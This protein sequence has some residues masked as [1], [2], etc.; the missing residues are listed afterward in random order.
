MLGGLLQY[1]KNREDEDELLA[2]F[3][4]FTPGNCRFPQYRVFIN[5]LVEKHQIRN[6]TQFSLN[7]EKG[8]NYEAF[9]PKE[10]I[11]VLKAL[12]VSDVM[13]DIKNAL[14]VL[15]VDREGAAAIFEEQ[16]ARVVQLFADFDLDNLNPLL[17]DACE[18]FRGIPLRY[19]LSEAKKVALMGEVFVRR[20][21]FSAGELMDRLIANEIVVKKSH[22]FEWLKYVDH[23]VKLGIYE[24][25]FNLKDK[26]QFEAKVFL[27]HRYEKQLKKIL[28]KSNL[29]DYEVVDLPKIFEYGTNFFDI[30]FR[31]ESMLVVGNFFKD[32]LHGY[33]GLV[34][35][36]PFACMPTRVIESVLSNEATLARKRQLEGG[37]GNSHYDGLEGIEDLPFL[38]IETDGNPFPQI[39]EARIEA[40]CLQ[41]ARL[42]ERLKTAQYHGV[43]TPRTLTGR[44]L[45]TVFPTRR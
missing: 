9:G 5:T 7:A 34:N 26:I 1:I 28:S 36:G 6:V 17:E 22:F 15:A 27:Q 2:Y 30:R 29:Y 40:F 10:R 33:H 18:V 41:V 19:P 3:M 4:P 8:Y 16:W 25:N 11:S 43:T 24:P 20:D 38:T 13:E 31:G 37:N 45:Q 21:Y 32:I 12:I 14:A 39:L 23:I 42:H 35:I 44:L